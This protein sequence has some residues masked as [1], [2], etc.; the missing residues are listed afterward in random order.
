M[1]SALDLFLG[2]FMLITQRSRGAWVGDRCLL[3]VRRAKRAPTQQIKFA[4]LDLRGCTRRTAHMT[5]SAALQGP[6]AQHWTVLH[7]TA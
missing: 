6:T 7:C 4:K 2:R 5:C 1:I 3:D